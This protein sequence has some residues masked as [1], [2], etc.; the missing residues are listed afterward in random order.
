MD[1]APQQPYA[2]PEVVADIRRGAARLARQLRLQRPAG[3]LSGTKL[4]VLVHLSMHGPSSPTDI[5]VA[6]QQKPQSLTRCLAQL[7]AE[8]LVHRGSSPTDAR[9][10]ILSLSERGLEALAA[11]MTSRDVWLLEAMSGLS[12]LELQILHLGAK[13]MD[14]I[15]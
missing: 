8:G 15:A 11:D 3:G 1:D 6:A 13:L 4:S 12:E 10:S 2:T 14:Q 5:A 7:E 9:S